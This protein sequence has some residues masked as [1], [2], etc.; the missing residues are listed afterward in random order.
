MTLS[1]ETTKLCQ[2]SS[3]SRRLECG[4]SRLPVTCSQYSLNKYCLTYQTHLAIYSRAITIPT[5]LFGGRYHWQNIEFI[6][7]TPIKPSIHRC[8]TL[9]NL[10]WRVEF[11]IRL[12]EEVTLCSKHNHHHNHTHE[13]HKNELNSSLSFNSSPISSRPCINSRCDN[14]RSTISSSHKTSRSENPFLEIYSDMYTQQQQQQ[15][16]PGR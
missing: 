12:A 4:A 15:Q 2:S 7:C 6:Y 1:F 13:Q 16:N 3:I 10:L 9:S 11:H 14:S 8:T 5:Y